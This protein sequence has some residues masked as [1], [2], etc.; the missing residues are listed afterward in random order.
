M[1]QADSHQIV[2]ARRR[3]VIA[4]VLGNGFEWYDFLIY[5]L[6]A[7]MVA[8]VLFPSSDAGLA[9]LMASAG[10]AVSFV[11]RPAG[12]LLFAIYAD[13]FGRK[14][15]LT[16]MLALM[17]GSTLMIGL[18]PPYAA[19]G[20][21][22]PMLLIGARL[23]QG[24]SVG[25]EFAT[26][27]A[28][29]TE[30]APPRQRM[31]YGSL[32]MCTQSLAMAMAAG[33]VAALS[34]SLAPEDMARWGWRVP[35]LLGALV[36]PVGF[37]LRR[38]VSES[39]AFRPPAPQGM[40]G[41]QPL[42]ELITLHRRR[43]VAGLGIV[44]IGTTSQYVWFVYLP[45]FVTGQLGLNVSAAM[46]GSALC[47]LL[48]VLLTLLTGMLADRWGPWRL[49]VAGAMA[50]GLL[51]WPLLAWVIARPELERLLAAQAIGTLAISL[52]WGP[53]PGLLAALYPMRMRSTG[54]SLCYNLGVL[55]FGGLAPFTL[56]WTTRMFDDR[57]M[58]AYYITAC[59]AIAL[60]ATAGQW[61]RSGKVGEAG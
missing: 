26:A 46:T 10:F 14:P 48:L 41:A 15:A 37:Y 1:M 23:V 51:A 32:Q 43:V 31:R 27:T 61:M 5:G 39:P 50:F 60:A 2:R 12:G 8:P 20:I 11:V 49:F 24:L 13:R 6:L 30:W 54:I 33:T 22:A 47:G 45:V 7:G 34:S 52:V 35:F 59:A 3:A 19:I 57:M 28:M 25:A 58:P 16:L 4:S 18:I 21:A 55:L 40:T 42:S 38:S 9:I 53:T 36:G 17:A 29:L 44:V 56:A